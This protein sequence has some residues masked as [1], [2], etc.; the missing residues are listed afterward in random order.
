MKMKIGKSA[1]LLASAGLS[2][3]CLPTLGQDVDDV[4]TGQ[5]AE[6]AAEQPGAAT[7]AQTAGRPQMTIGAGIS[8]QADA[9]IHNTDQS[10]S[11]TRL[12]LSLGVPI[13]LN[14]A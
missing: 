14:D 11:I 12:D 9:D 1:W 5:I 13:Q 4:K 2:L 7:P 10:F 3:M 8:Y 6:P